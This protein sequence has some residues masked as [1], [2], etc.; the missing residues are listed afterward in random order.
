MKFT[1]AVLAGLFS[2]TSALAA[3]LPA[4]VYTKAP[5]YVDPGYN[6]TGFYLGGNLGYSWG[7]S[8]D[9]ST[10][11]NGAGT[12]LSTSIGRSNL[13]G[14]VGGGQ[15]GYNWQMQSWV[16]GLEG[17]IQ[18]TGERGSRDISCATGVCTPSTVTTTTT[19]RTAP[20]FFAAAPPII[21]TTTTTTTPGPA[22][23]ATLTQKIDWFGTVGARG[24]VLVTP[25]ILFYA[26][27]GLAY[28]QVNSSETISGS[29]FSASDIR[30]GYTV[31][32][33]IEGAIG[34]NWTAKL[35]YLF[36]DLGRTSGSFAT[37]IPASG[38]GTLASNY[39]SHVTDNVLRFGINYNFR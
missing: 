37:A 8:S 22:I 38:G 25:R 15:A 18:G 35:E 6:W 16:W 29:P 28:G 10:F 24:G 14:I 39:S 31:G 32:G 36:V 21:T 23:P 7:R 34:G 9:T 3:D 30:V 17:D 13:D 26:T 12:L 20:G 11:T 5:V 1:V 33:G 19:T 27:G 4:P 2:A